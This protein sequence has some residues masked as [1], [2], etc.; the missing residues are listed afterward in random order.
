MNFSKQILIASAL[1]AFNASAFSQMSILSGPKNGSGSEM[2]SDIVK[3]LGEKNGLKL[4]NRATGGSAYNFT[5]LL[6]PSTTDKIAL[7]PADYLNMMIGEPEFKN[8]TIILN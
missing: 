2:V 6:N 5:A 4:S 3:V 1:F 8:I 7:I